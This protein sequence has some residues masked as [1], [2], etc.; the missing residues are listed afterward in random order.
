MTLSIRGQLAAAAVE[1]FL[2]QVVRLHPFSEPLTGFPLAAGRKLLLIHN[3]NTD[4]LLPDGFTVVRVTDVVKV[5]STEWDRFAERV[6]ADEGRLLDPAAVPSVRLGS[7]AQ[8]LADLHARA[9]RVSVECE[10]QEDG[11]FLGAIRGLRR[12]EV[13]IRPIDAAGRWEDEQW[14][15]RYRDVTQVRFGTRYIEVFSRYAGELPS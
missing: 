13:E 12:D 3:L 7:W 4:L 9:E 6:L 15:I 1:G 2:V 8:L 14:W 10:P 11:Y 5:R